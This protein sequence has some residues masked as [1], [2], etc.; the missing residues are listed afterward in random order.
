MKFASLAGRVRHLRKDRECGRWWL[1]YLRSMDGKGKESDRSSEVPSDK[2]D[3][4]SAGHWSDNSVPMDVD[5]GLGNE[6]QPVSRSLERCPEEGDS[7]SRCPSNPPP[8]LHH[9][10]SATSAPTSHVAAIIDDY[11]GTAEIVREE[12]NLYAKL[13]KT[14]EFFDQRN[15]TGVYYPFS[16]PVE[17]EIAQWLHGLNASM[18]QVNQFF[19]LQYVKFFHLF[20]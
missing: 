2:T 10:A 1:K 7:H 11:A 9:L 13:W 15:K 6:N 8:S 3:K 5:F 4:E 18:D 12:D 20:P 17:W 16:G 19:N 14:D